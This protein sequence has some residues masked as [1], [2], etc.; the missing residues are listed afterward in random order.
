[1]S[2][3]GKTSE[4]AGTFKILYIEREREKKSEGI[5]N[6]LSILNNIQGL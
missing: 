6:I 3:A 1:M 4:T 5:L 2:K